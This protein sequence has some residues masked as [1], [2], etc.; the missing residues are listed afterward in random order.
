M[1]V[2][3]PT[4][5]VHHRFVSVVNVIRDRTVSSVVKH[6]LE[7]VRDGEKYVAQ[8]I[9]EDGNLVIAR[10]WRDN[11]LFMQACKKMLTFALGK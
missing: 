2:N 5:V 3:K 1:N 8:P 6:A 7:C 9:L 10:T 11:A 4:T